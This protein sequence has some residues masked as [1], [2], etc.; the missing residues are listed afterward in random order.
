MVANVVQNLRFLDKKCYG[1]GVDFV[2]H[3]AIVFSMHLL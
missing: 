3:N 1:S 2:N